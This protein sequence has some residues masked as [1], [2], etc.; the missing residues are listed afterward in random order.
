MDHNVNAAQRLHDQQ[1]ASSNAA[2]SEAATLAGVAARTAEE[3]DD[4]DVSCPT[5]PWRSSAK[6]W[7]HRS[8]SA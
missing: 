6:K 3:C 4:G 8:P 1:E 2:C 5:C 7:N